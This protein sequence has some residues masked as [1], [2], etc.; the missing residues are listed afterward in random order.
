MV[1]IL[2]SIPLSLPW[3]HLDA[4]GGAG[5]AGGGGSLPLASPSPSP[6]SS[7]SVMCAICP[8]AN[9]SIVESSQDK[10]FIT[11]VIIYQKCYEKT[12]HL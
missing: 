11:S 3:L 2:I 5:V 7:I 1:S 12:W 9:F 6:S 8:A 4:L 10:M